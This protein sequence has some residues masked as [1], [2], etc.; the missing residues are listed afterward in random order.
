VTPLAV[1]VADG[2]P[3]ELLTADVDPDH[4]FGVAML[5]AMAPAQAE[6]IRQALRL[7]AD[8]NAP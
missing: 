1:E 2:L 8:R 7:I 3:P 6:V 5:D 4:P